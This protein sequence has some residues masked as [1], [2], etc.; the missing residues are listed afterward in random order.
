MVPAG[1]KAHLTCE[2]I[3]AATVESNPKPEALSAPQRTPNNIRNLALQGNIPR[4]QRAFAARLK[5]YRLLDDVQGAGAFF[6]P[7]ASEPFSAYYLA[8]TA[9]LIFG[10]TFSAINTMERLASAGS[11][12]SLPA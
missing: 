4:E 11:R 6:A 8:L 10:S 5:N 1:R 2:L 12:Q 9:A 3:S 7:P